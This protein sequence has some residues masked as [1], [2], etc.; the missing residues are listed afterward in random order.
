MHAILADILITVNKIFIFESENHRVLFNIGENVQECVST[1]Y[2]NS[3][4]QCRF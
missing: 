1:W 2:V 3:I 4:F